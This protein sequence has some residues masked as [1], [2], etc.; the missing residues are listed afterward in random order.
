MNPTGLLIYT[1]LSICIFFAEPNIENRIKYIQPVCVYSQTTFPLSP[2]F[3]ISLDRKCCCL[4][5]LYKSVLKDSWVNNWSPLQCSVLLPHV[6]STLCLLRSGIDG[7]SV[8][9]R[10]AIHRHTQ[11][12][13]YSHTTKQVFTPLH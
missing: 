2:V 5:K 6:F 4:Y 11:V 3:S 8:K 10:T 1:R 12:G 9:K 7:G 13:Q